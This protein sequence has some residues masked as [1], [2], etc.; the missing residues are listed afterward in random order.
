MK[1][2]EILKKYGVLPAEEALSELK[3]LSDDEIRELE[4]KIVRERPVFIDKNFVLSVKKPKIEV[5]E[6]APRKKTLGIEE[7]VEILNEYFEFFSEI[8]KARVNPLRL[9]SISSVREP[10]YYGV[11]GMVKEISEKDEFLIIE[12]EDK[13]GCIRCFIDKKFVESDENRIFRDEVI[14]VEGKLENNKFIAEKIIFPEIEKVKYARFEKETVLYARNDGDTIRISVNSNLYTVSNP[15]VFFID[16]IQILAF[17]NKEN[18]NPIIFLKKRTLTPGKIALYSLI[19]STPH[20]LI[21][22]HT[23]SYRASYKGVKIFG[24]DKKEEIRIELK[25]LREKL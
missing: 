7:F 5:F 8:I 24:L 10:G 4:K 11:I 25:N 19:K 23:P 13:T 17:L 16:Q 22:T 20:A 1:I 21:T 15:C 14:G 3:F 18:L 9:V 6:L 12:L 2:N